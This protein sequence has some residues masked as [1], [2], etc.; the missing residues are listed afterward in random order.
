MSLGSK[1]DPPANSAQSGGA[2]A[3]FRRVVERLLSTLTCW[4]SSDQLLL[5]K[6]PVPG[7]WLMTIA[8]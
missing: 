7:C 4:H 6:W 5:R 1:V 3:E 2:A 8:V